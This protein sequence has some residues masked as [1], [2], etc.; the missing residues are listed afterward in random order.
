[1]RRLTP[2]RLVA[3][4]VLAA[5][6]VS[7]ASTDLVAA[8]ITVVGGLAVVLALRHRS[9]SASRRALLAVIAGATGV[10]V[11]AALA[12]PTYHAR[13]DPLVVT[14]PTSGGPAG[15]APALGAV[16]GTGR[17]TALGFV[18][19][20]YDDSGAGVDRDVASL[21][22]LAATGITLAPHPGSIVVHPAGDVLVRAHIGG[23]SGLAVVSN[24]N[25][26]AFDGPRAATMLHSAQ[27]RHRFISALTGEMA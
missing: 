4:V 19:S 15:T 6:L 11:M 20:D 26:T 22:T 18:A 16:A 1:M 13:P 8:G 14:T 24:Y 5:F 3:V 10:A 23:A 9:R 17:F 27:Y 21:S 25:G 7:L 2:P 12:L